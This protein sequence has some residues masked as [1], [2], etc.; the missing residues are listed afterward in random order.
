MKKSV[1]KSEKKK[2]S[3]PELEVTL[4][5]VSDVVRVSDYGEDH[6]VWGDYFAA[7]KNGGDGV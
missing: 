6:D 3:T 4:L 1:S 7:D 2:Y 5:N